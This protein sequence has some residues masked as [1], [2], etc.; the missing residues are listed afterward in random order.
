MLYKNNS[1]IKPMYLGNMLILK[2]TPNNGEILP[3]KPPIPQTKY[4]NTP[5]QDASIYKPWTYEG[6]IAEY[7][8][9][10]NSSNGYI[11]KHRYED[12]S[13]QPILTQ[14]GNYELYSYVLEPTNYTKTIFIQAGIHG[15]EMDAKQQLLRIVDILVNKTNMSGYEA[16]KEIRNNVRL[17]IIP[18][19]SPF[20]H[21][22][23][24][25][26]VP[27]ADNGSEVQYGINL[28]RNYDFNQQYAI[29]SGGVGGY[30]EMCMEE[31]QHTKDVIEGVGVENINY[32]MD[33]HDGREVQ[34]H[35]WIN[36]SADAGN[37][38]IVDDFIKYLI[39]KY[40][41]E[42]PIIDNC[43]DT[44]TTGIASMYFAKT[45]GIIGSTVE[46][47]GGILG[48]DFNSE[49]MTKSMEVRANMLL[50]AYTENIK[51]WKINESVD[52]GYF[53]FDYP[54]AFTRAGLRY[55]SSD[56]RTIVTDQQI[57]NRWDK[58]YTTHPNLITKSSK[59][60]TNVDGT[61]DI[62]TYTFGSGYNKVLYV[63]GIK[64]YG[65][66]CKIDEFAIY[67]LVEYLCNDYIV[68]Q[69]KFLQDLKNNYTII[70]LPCIDNKAG[71]VTGIQ[72]CGLNNMALNFK[73]WQIIEDKCQPTTYALG[74]NDIPIVKSIIDNNH[75]LKCIVSGGEDC[76]KYGANTQ[77]Y[78]TEFET[79]FV[80]PK[81][82]ISSTQLLA[83]KSHL[84]T[85]RNENVII[86]NTI[87]YGIGDYAYDNYSIPTYYV[88][89][90]VSKKYNELANYH[91]LSEQDYLHS[92][93]EAGRRMANIV[94][95]FLS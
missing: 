38:I 77:D 10:M 28:N 46:W 74:V 14:N 90:K 3:P 67:E 35:Y 12:N 86:E 84:E 76:S 63:G 21:D 52:A 27:Y 34:Q 23:A 57:Y 26:N 95:L 7:D 47:I 80:I 9:L 60:G 94:N 16:F 83:Y 51:G 78:S 49:H 41:I 25:L 72:E 29:A 45:M 42:N 81:N 73:K 85:N 65:A 36:Y 6:L 71:N 75:D 30:P 62:Y 68:N 8:S 61:Q 20:G 92:N 32:A 19:V 1:I 89:L 33:W 70:V 44:S 50:L 88:Q 15:N 91:T 93:Y 40:N 43:K 37:R 48:Y 2:A 24:S 64:R 5:T 66:T 53:H 31:I 55:D 17:V 58:L 39:N 87:G 22:N 69:S 79:Q 13:N 56:S 59:L 54:K 4:W 82:Q 11:T 18:C